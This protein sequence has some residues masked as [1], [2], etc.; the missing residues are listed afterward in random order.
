MAPAF[1]GRR[2]DPRRETDGEVVRRRRALAEIGDGGDDLGELIGV[3]KVGREETVV[4]GGPTQRFDV[5][6][7]SRDPHRHPGLLHWSGQKLDALDGVVLAAVVHRLT[8]PGGGE[9]LQCLVEY[10]AS[11]PIIE[12]FAGFGQ[13]AAEAVA[14]E[15]HA[16]GQAATAEPVQ[17]RGFPGDLDR[18]RLAS[19]V[20]MGPNRM[21]SV[22]VAIAASVIH[23]SATCRTGARQRR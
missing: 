16:E 1:V 9:D 4:P 12:L 3:F 20:T 10:L 22:A 11:Q 2:V 19:G 8:G 7:E 18:P 13:L 17:G 21:R 6:G 5:A 14:T 15:T 23:G